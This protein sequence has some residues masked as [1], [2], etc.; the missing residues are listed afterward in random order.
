MVREWGEEGAEE[1]GSC[2]SIAQVDI[3]S[4]EVS[5]PKP[6]P[7][8]PLPEACCRHRGGMG[9]KKTEH[10]PP[11]PE[12]VYALEFKGGREGR[13]GHH[14]CKGQVLPIVIFSF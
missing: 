5:S 1:P 4:H 13:C 3:S 14:N 11:T 7:L 10:L 9:K 12:I 2:S 6:S 8:F